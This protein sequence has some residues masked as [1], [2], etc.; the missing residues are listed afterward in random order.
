MSFDIPSNHSRAAKMVEIL[1]HVERSAKSN[2]ATPAEITEMLRPVLVA[3]HKVGAQII[4]D[5]PPLPAPCSGDCNSPA[6][7]EMPA[8]AWAAPKNPPAWASIRDAAATAPLSDLT[9]AMAVF[10]NRIDAE[11]KGGDA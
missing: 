6:P 8:G 10:I 3:L 4:P 11:L 9:F 1:G 2:R 7:T 5:T